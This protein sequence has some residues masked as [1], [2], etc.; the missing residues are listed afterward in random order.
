[1]TKIITFPQVDRKQ[2]INTFLFTKYVIR[3]YLSLQADFV[4]LIGCHRRVKSVLKARNC[5]FDH[6]R[7]KAQEQ[8]IEYCTNKQKDV[9]SKIIELGRN[10]VNLLP[11]ADDYLSFHDKCQLLNVN[12]IAAGKKVNND[13]SITF[14]KMI[15][16]HALEYRGAKDSLPYLDISMP[17]FHAMQ[18][19][20]IHEMATNPEFNAITNK[21][22]E[23]LLG[24][25]AV[26]INQ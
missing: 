6:Q 13:E 17:F 23:E 21:F 18:K 25:Q 1:M 12:H 24:F 7:F 22:P 19:H 4:G 11:I 20:I 9:E 5:A 3:R 8:M 2:V 10:I 14:K 26:P 16:V 15:F